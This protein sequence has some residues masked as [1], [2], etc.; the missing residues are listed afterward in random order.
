MKNNRVVLGAAVFFCL[1]GYGSADELV[2]SP[3]EKTSLLTS[4]HTPVSI[5]DGINR[6]LV[7]KTGIAVYGWL[8][9]GIAINEY[10]QKNRYDS[11]WVSPV[12][13]QLGGYS[14]NSHLLIMEQQSDLKLNQLWFGVNRTL[15][16]RKGFDWGFEVDTAYG[17]DLRYI[18]C[19]GDKSFDY[20]WGQ[21]DYFLSIAC[22]Y[23]DIGYKNL[24]VRVGKFSTE[25]SNEIFPATETFFYTKAYAF[26]NSPT[27]SG[28]KAA[29]R[30]NDRWTVLGAW[31]ASDGAS[32]ENRFDDAGVLF[33]VRFT[34]TKSTSLKYSC[35]LEHCN[36]LNR[37]SDAAERFGR[38]YL[39]RDASSHHVVFQWDINLRWRFEAEGF[40]HSRLMRRDINND[41]GFSNGYNLNLYYKFNE[42]WSVGTRYEWLKACNTLFDLPY[43]TGGNGTEINALAFAVSWQPTYRLNFRTELRHDWTDYNNGYR[44]FNAGTQSDQLLLGGAM[45]VK[46]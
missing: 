1:C 37:R 29:Y 35:F 33:Q 9:T 21:G 3:C 20:N 22:L 2:C 41:T 27:V 38:D 7:P 44:P 5:F 36:G 4:P 18:Q 30:I 12:H 43:L 28:V 11:P 16:T 32:F 19:N 46:F 8:Q 26:W 15:D 13:R 17:T 23:G 31:T 42:R 39:T 34:P 24:S 25:M 40:T 14:G 10:G 6:K 45:T